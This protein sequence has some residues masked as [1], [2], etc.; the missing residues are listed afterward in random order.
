MNIE[1]DIKN[2]VLTFKLSGR[3]DTNSSPS[4]E[5]EVENIE[6]SI[7][8][9]IF[10]FKNLEYISSAGLRILIQTKKKYG[11]VKIINFNNDIKQI[12][13]MTGI[14]GFFINT[15]DSDFKKFKANKDELDD[16]TNFLDSFL[17]R[18]NVET[19]IISQLNV[20]IEELFIN[21]C[22]YAYKSI[23]DSNYCDISFNLDNDILSIK[24]VDSGVEFNPI[25]KE[26]PDVSLD[27]KDRNIGGLGI[28]IV[29]KTMDDVSYKREDAKNILII[30]KKVK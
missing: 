12:L 11:D 2:T 30:K 1:K 5:K 18:N 28:Y 6:S 13:E 3:L 21:V 7:R 29:K 15:C 23:S 26:D 27:A 8:S 4:L 22:F 20:V 16:V 9:I 19:K 25:D 14:L 17:E 24:L 10:D